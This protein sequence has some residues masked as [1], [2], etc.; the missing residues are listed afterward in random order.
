MGCQSPTINVLRP[1]VKTVLPYQTHKTN[2]Q[3]GFHQTTNPQS[4]RPAQHSPTGTIK[5]PDLLSPMHPP[6]LPFPWKPNE[7]SLQQEELLPSP[8]PT[9]VTRA[10]QARQ[11]SFL[12]ARRQAA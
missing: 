9:C 12:I 2:L 6:S 8:A 3:W 4:I 10:P 11:P 5:Q 7:R 1:E